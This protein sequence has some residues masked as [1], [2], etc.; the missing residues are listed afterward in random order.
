MSSNI[1][2]HLR[3][4]ISD[5]MEQ[6]LTVKGTIYCHSD[7]TAFSDIRLKEDLQPIENALEKVNQ[8]H[9]VTFHMKNGDN[10]KKRD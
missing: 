7:I 8:L 3:K 2:K 5:T 10:K 6:N 1:N 4:D 9:G